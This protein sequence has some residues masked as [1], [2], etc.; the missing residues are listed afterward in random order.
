MLKKNPPTRTA[1]MCTRCRN[2]GEPFV[3]LKGHRKMCQWRTCECDMCILIAQRGGLNREKAKLMEERIVSNKRLRGKR[4]KSRG[5][6]NDDYK[7]DQEYNPG[8]TLSPTQPTSLWL[9][10]IPPPNEAPFSKPPPSYQDSI[11][12]PPY[13]ESNTAQQIMFCKDP[14]RPTP[15]YPGYPLS[16]TDSID[17]LQDNQ[18]YWTTP[19][20]IFPEPFFE[21]TQ[22]SPHSPKPV[23]YDREFESGKLQE[24]QVSP[25]LG[26]HFNFGQIRAGSGSAN[27]GRFQTLSRQGVS[28]SPSCGSLPWQKIS[29]ASSTMPTAYYTGQMMSST[30][31][32]H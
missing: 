24:L 31:T 27:D 25:V 1:P 26:D 32:K 21:G 18:S 3:R 28:R 29:P 12:P 15:G 17:T 7:N 4:D 5:D 23:A 20:R 10:V 11:R 2:H 8:C 14:I 19:F 6:S 9:P 13:Q 22:T 16:F 30:S